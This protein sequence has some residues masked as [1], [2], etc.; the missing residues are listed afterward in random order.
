MRIKIREVT[1]IRDLPLTYATAE[2]SYVIEPGKVIGGHNY[3]VHVYNF[4]T[5]VASG[6]SETR[7]TGRWEAKSL[8]RKYCRSQGRGSERGVIKVEQ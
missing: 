2:W 6:Y 3:Y 7:W 8:V 1:P 4:G 5:R